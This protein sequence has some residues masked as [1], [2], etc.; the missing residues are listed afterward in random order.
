MTKLSQLADCV[1]T[2]ECRW[3]CLVP[4]FEAAYRHHGLFVSTR[5]GIASGWL[6]FRALRPPPLRSKPAAPLR[7]R[8]TSN[9][10]GQGAVVIIADWTGRRDICLCLCCRVIL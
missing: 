6:G 1:S 8:R 10:A 4:A 7:T 2:N 5:C 3:F 9:L